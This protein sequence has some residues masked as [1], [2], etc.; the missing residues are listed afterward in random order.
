MAAH[1]AW[2][3]GY[4]GSH[5]QEHSIGNKHGLHGWRRT[6]RGCGSMARSGQA[7]GCFVTETS[8]L[9]K[10]SARNALRGRDRCQTSLHWVSC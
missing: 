1:R 4:A 9:W 3:D 8:L 10:G 6:G 7:V 5:E 2:P